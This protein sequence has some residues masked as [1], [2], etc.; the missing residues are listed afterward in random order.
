[1]GFKEPRDARS[2][3][4]ATTFWMRD[5]CAANLAGSPVIRTCSFLELAMTIGVGRLISDFA[6]TPSDAMVC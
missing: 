4:S 6:R 5:A 2:A 1:M 3:I